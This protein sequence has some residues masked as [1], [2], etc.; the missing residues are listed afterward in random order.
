M[1]P[2]SADLNGP[3][4]PVPANPFYHLDRRSADMLCNVY[5]WFRTQPIQ[6][7][8]EQQQIKEGKV[9]TS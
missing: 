6:T 3:V 2:G 9:A 1:A 8:T 7:V 5:K 4:I